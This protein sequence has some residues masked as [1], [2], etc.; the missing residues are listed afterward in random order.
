MKVLIFTCSSGNGHNSAA[1]RITE[2]FKNHSSEHEILTIDMYKKYAS[3]LVSWAMEDGYFLLCNHF[4]GIYNYFLKKAEESDISKYDIVSANDNTFNYLNG[5]L[6]DIFEFKPDLIICTYVL[7]A[8]AMTNI[9][10]AYNIPAKVA[11]M[12][13][14]YGV[15]PYWECT[16]KGLDYMFLTDEYM[17]EKFIERGFKKEQLHVVGTPISPKFYVKRNKEETR[18]K[19][20]LDKSL[21]TIIF[22]KASF[23]PY[24]DRSIVKELS[25][26]KTPCQIVI[27]NGR[28]DKSRERIDK[29]LKKLNL[30]H[31]ILNL[32][33][34]NNIPEYFSAADLVIGKAGGLTS[35]ELIASGVPSLIVEKLPQQEIRN[36]E[37]L[38]SHGCSLFVNKNTIAKTVN[39]IIEDKERYKEMKENVKKIQTYNAIGKMF[40]VLINSPK[41]LYTEE[42]FT[43]TKSETKRKVKAKRKLDVKNCK[44]RGNI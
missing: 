29:Y 6:K 40:D 3:K 19:L 15:S 43:E 34:V 42:P 35:A 13:L 28:C 31:K 30:P 25:K 4:M 38:I 26:I 27:I 22:M 8:V 5:M 24:S 12:T 20:S 36:G 41:A 1:K 16:A 39:S 14:D 10:R 23:F 18:E 21:F 44:N 37:Y 9:K 7:T 2:A 33:F 11:C 17:I 32:G